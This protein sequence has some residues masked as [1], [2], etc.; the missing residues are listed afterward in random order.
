[1]AKQIII[2]AAHDHAAT[3]NPMTV[4]DVA[5]WLAV[6]TA[7]QPFYA[8]PNATSA[9]S[10]ASAGE[11]AALQNGSVVEMVFTYQVSGTQTLT[12]IKTALQNIWTTLQSNIT[13]R[14]LWDRYGSFWDG[15]TWTSG[16]VV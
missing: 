9:W 11:I 15:T 4:Y 5:Y 7:R 13:A 16:G 3:D 6:P 8:D 12:Q 2:L 10:G 1:M 14:N